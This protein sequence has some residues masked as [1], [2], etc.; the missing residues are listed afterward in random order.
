MTANEKAQE[1]LGS[2]R[3]LAAKDAD[4]L[5]STYGSLKDIILAE[6][7]KEF[8]EINGISDAKIE[9]LTACFKGNIACD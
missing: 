4:A 1:V 5:L 2:V 7:Y 6:D 9:S 3:R 8:A